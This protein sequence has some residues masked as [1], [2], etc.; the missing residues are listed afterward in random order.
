MKLGHARWRERVADYVDGEL[1][2]A[3]GGEVEAHLATCPACRE[4]A[5]RLRGLLAAA[6]TLP[7]TVE[8]RR[9]LW[10]DVAAALD[11]PAGG[12]DS[13]SPPVAGTGERDGLRSRLE[14]RSVWSSR[15][16]LAAAAVVLVALSSGATALI[17]TRS[18]SGEGSRAVAPTPASPVGGAGGWAGVEEGYLRAAAELRATLAEQRER[19]EPEAWNA[20]ERNLAILDGAIVEAREALAADPDNREVFRML[21][22]MYEKKIDVLRQV[23]ALPAG[24]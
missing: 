2:A 24:T 16:W 22:S 5:V 6:A 8:P 21:S 10:P 1:P 9:D 20:V 14:A 3:R 12:R 13:E 18:G 23:A 19:L 11:D 17:L 15:R 7:R 4:E